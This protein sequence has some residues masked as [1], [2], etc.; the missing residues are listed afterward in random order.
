MSEKRRDKY[1]PVVVSLVEVALGFKRRQIYA[2]E[3]DPEL[4]ALITMVTKPKVIWFRSRE[5]QLFQFWRL[6][7][8]GAFDPD[9]WMIFT[10]VVDTPLWRDLSDY[11]GGRFGSI[12]IMRYN[13]TTKVGVR[14]SQRGI[15]MNA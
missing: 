15:Y 8:E 1:L 5:D 7:K 4:N 6:R 3:T 9:C 12:Y 10:G 11:V 2:A 13:G 14:P